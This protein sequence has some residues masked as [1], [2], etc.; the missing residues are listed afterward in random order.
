[1][2]KNDW[3][4]KVTEK[5]IRDFEKALFELK[6]LKG[7]DAQPWLRRAQKESLEAELTNL[8]KQVDEYKLLQTG[9]VALPGPE[10]IQQVADALIKTRIGKGLN[11][12]QLAA[13]L[14]VSKQ[15]VQQYEQTNY[16]HVTLS[17]A[18]R[19]MQVILESKPSSVQRKTASLARSAGKKRSQEA[20][21]KK[22]ASARK[23]GP[24]KAAGAPAKK[25][26][27]PSKKSAKRS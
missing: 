19:V 3:Q 24:S 12:E 14:G 16:A 23:T 2:I 6:H 9:T 5:R 18:H 15:C 27:V 17:T 11:Q 20:S 7:G 10:V 8:R 21:K 22:P 4:L 13:R 1:M 26:S 25:K